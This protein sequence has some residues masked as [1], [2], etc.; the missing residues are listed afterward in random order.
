MIVTP[1]SASCEVVQSKLRTPSTLFSSKPALSSSEVPAVAPSRYKG[2]KAQSEANQ[3]R[4]PTL[5]PSAH[6]AHVTLR[7]RRHDAGKIS[8]DEKFFRASQ[9]GIKLPEKLTLRV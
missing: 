2:Q 9:C 3:Q 7:T 8:G 6:A 1:T 4:P 5:A